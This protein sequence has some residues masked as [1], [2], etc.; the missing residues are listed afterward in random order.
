MAKTEAKISCHTLSS[1]VFET[2]NKHAL[3]YYLQNYCKEKVQGIV[4]CLIVSHVLWGLRVRGTRK[5]FILSP[6]TTDVYLAPSLSLP[7]HPCH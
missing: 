1:L 4:S 5:A 6:G 2:C 3:V 7:P